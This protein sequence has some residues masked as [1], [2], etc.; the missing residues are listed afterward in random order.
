MLEGTSNRHDA[1]ALDSVVLEELDAGQRGVLE[2][3]GY[4]GDYT[5]QY[6]QADGN[7]DEDGVPTPEICW[8]T[9]VV[10]HLLVL[11]TEEWEAF[12]EGRFEDDIEEDT[13]ADE[14]KR[15]KSAASAA[16]QRRRGKTKGRHGTANGNRNENGPGSR[17]V[18]RQR[19]RP[20]SALANEKIAAWLEA[21]CR[22][23][24][25][26]LK[27]LKDMDEE[28]ITNDFGGDGV[29]DGEEGGR[30][31]E[32]RRKKEEEDRVKVRARA[33][34][35]YDMV[36]TRWTQIRGMCWAGREGLS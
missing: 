6:S 13:I 12:V 34:V 8:R 30:G 7:G 16:R 35:R 9:Q 32:G 14:G 3:K 2:A 29:F 23:A 28:E 21:Y 36:V 18:A 26:S 24:E 31:R 5:L 10:A 33:R 19:T 27:M 4:L 17:E 22:K 1:V 25:S 11:T 20:A 15:R